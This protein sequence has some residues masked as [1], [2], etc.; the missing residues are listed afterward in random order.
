[1]AAAAA[2]GDNSNPLVYSSDSECEDL[3]GSLSLGEIENWDKVEESEV[4]PITP[5]EVFEII[6]RLRDPEHP[7]LSLEQL[8][9]VTPEQIQVTNGVTDGITRIDVEFTPTIPTCSVAT[10]IGLTIRTKL[11]KCVCG[12]NGNVKI[13]VNIKEGTHDQ[14]EQVNK[15]LNDKERCQAA[16]ENPNLQKVLLQSGPFP[17]TEV[18]SCSSHLL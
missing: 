13:N 11:Q 17:S 14:E 9:V 4:D 6:R 3:L 15:Q 5:V 8:R 7:T 1:M 10:L 12:A 2:L 18:P 16:I